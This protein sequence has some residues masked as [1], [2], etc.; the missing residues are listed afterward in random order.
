MIRTL[1][2]EIAIDIY[3]SEGRTNNF[4]KYSQMKE[5][6]GWKVHQIFMTVIANKMSEYLLSDKFTKL[7]IQEKDAQQRACHNTKE[8][9]DFLFDPLKGAKN[10]MAADICARKR[11]EAT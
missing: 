4:F 8:M 2:R 9:I 11:K 10:Y 6:E 7:D 1:L 5:T 3:K